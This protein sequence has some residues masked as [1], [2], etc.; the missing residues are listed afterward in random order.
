MIPSP[1]PP[2]AFGASATFA[3]FA[4]SGRD[5]LGLPARFVIVN[6]KETAPEIESG[7]D[8]MVFAVQS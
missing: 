5:A 6:E 4:L 2:V 7:L 1:L 8:Q 3:P